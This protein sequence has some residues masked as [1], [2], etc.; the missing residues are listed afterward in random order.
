M[1]T[2]TVTKTAV[3]VTNMTVTSSRARAPYGGCHAV[4][5]RDSDS[6]DVTDRR[7]SDMPGLEAGTSPSRCSAA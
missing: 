3:T 2:S 1:K 5:V 4:T 7:D 6:R